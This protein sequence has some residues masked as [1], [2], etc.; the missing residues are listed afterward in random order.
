MARACIEVTDDPPQEAHKALVDGLT[1]H[2]AQVPGRGFAPR[3]L[4]ILLRDRESG[5]VQGGLM[6]RTDKDWLFVQLFF[7]P[8]AERGNGLG[9]RM[10]HLAEDE[11]RARG[12]RHAWLDTFSFQA[13]DF[14]RRHGYHEFGVLPDYPAGYARH[15]FTKNL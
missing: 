1:A 8:E 10:L 14:Y 9:S 2:S 4:A 15:F 6:G 13:P 3:P 11:A 7:V 12:C 5:S